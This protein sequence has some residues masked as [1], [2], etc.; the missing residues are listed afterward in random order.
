MTASL[1]A[2][3]I[4]TGWPATAMAVLTRQASAPISIAS[5]AWLGAPIPA[6]TTT[7]TEACS[8]MMR[9]KSRV[10]KP[11]FVPMGAASGMTVAAPASSSRLHNVGSAWQ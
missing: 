7:G 4:S 10:C 3:A 2:I 1:K 5:V 8:I 6:S 9:R 11:L